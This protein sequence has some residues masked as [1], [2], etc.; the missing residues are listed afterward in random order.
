MWFYLST[1]THQMVDNPLAVKILLHEL[2]H[3]KLGLH[4]T[5]FGIRMTQNER[6]NSE[7]F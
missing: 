1:D 3:N 7:F 5:H 2:L 6:A 4:A